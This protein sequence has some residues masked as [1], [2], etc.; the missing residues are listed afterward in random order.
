MGVVEGEVSDRFRL[1]NVMVAGVFPEDSLDGE[2]EYENGLNEGIKEV[3]D[4]QRLAHEFSA[5][6]DD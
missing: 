5:V 6:Y 3:T 2:G 4:D 1:G